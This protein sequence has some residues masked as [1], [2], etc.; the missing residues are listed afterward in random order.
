[1]NVRQWVG[2]AVWSLLMVGVMYFLG[3]VASIRDLV[4]AVIAIVV[5]F[6]I[7]RIKKDRYPKA[8]MFSRMGLY[9][10][11]LVVAISLVMSLV[12]LQRMAVA[13]GGYGQYFFDFSVIVV[14]IGALS[15]FLKSK[16]DHFPSSPPP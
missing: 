4:T 6:L 1:M 10:G 14:A 16:K 9:F 3:G 7:F 13:G 5:L 12:W 8:M 2:L 11:R 15:F